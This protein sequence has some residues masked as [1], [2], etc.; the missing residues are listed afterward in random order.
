MLVSDI[1]AEVRKVVKERPDVYYNPD[2]ICKYSSGA[3]SDGSIGCIFGQVFTN[4]GIDAK[5]FDEYPTPEGIS[6]TIYGG[7]TYVPGIDCILRH[8]FNCE[9]I[10]ELEWCGTVQN[11]Q[12][13]GLSWKEAVL[14]ADRE[15]GIEVEHDAGYRF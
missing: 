15:L 7:K 13:G 3:C 9:E 2:G 10:L 14:E 6:P 8:E 4:L 1:I 12:D 5:K 11:G